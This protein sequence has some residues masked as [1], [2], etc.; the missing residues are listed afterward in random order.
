MM[1]PSTPLLELMRGTAASIHKGKNYKQRE[2]ITFADLS[3]ADFFD[4][5]ACDITTYVCVATDR[6]SDMTN[7]IS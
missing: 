5:T 6:P 2:E 4:V 3:F 7:G 1:D